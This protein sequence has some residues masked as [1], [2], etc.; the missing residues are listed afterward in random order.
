[1]PD[2]DAVICDMYISVLPSSPLLS[3]PPVVS[4][5]C[6]CAICVNAMHTI[7]AIAASIAIL[8]MLALRT[9]LIVFSSSANSYSLFRHIVNLSMPPTNAAA[10]NSNAAIGATNIFL[11]MST[12]PWKLYALQPICYYVKAHHYQYEY[13]RTVEYCEY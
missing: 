13:P 2:A 6:E 4:V 12:K 5:V 1:V 8:P 10:M 7:N 3:V 9:I 11:I